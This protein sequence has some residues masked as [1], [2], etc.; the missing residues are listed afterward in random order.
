MGGNRARDLELGREA[1]A[2]KLSES[3]MNNFV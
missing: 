1:M 2:L 3:V